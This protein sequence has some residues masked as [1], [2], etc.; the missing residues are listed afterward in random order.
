MMVVVSD[1]SVLCYLARLGRLDVLETLF[2]EV[3]IPNAVLRECVHAG[4]P[5]D[6]RHALCGD[7]PSFIK[8]SG[9]DPVPLL[10]T[11]TLDIGEATA[12][13]I[14]WQHRA[15]SLLPLDEKRGRAIAGS[16][17]LRLR[18]VLGII[19]ECHRRNI[20][21]FD[22]TIAGLRKFGFRIAS[23]AIDAAR[24]QLGLSS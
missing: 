16:L 23:P 7:I 24:K 11:A 8:V 14:A 10:E 3:L 9:N 13:T 6:L 15:D 12:I 5:E 18:G 21:D 1:T 19:V 22:S 17:G 4:A 20:L 2:G